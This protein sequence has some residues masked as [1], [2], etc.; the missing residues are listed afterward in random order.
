MPP[1]HQNNF[2]VF[3]IPVVLQEGNGKEG[4]FLVREKDAMAGKFV[5]SCIHKGGPTHHIID[6]ST[7]PYVTFNG[8]PCLNCYT[9]D[10]VVEYLHY[11]HPLWPVVITASVGDL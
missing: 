8:T 10:D 4:V 11:Q 3:L 2:V 5:L 9:L 7:Q 1:L 6:V